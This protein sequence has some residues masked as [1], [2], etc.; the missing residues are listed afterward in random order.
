MISFL[1]KIWGLARPYRWRLWL[2]VL[3]GIIAGVIE[4]LLIFSV[5]FVY[6]V[7]FPSATE[8]LDSR[9]KHLPAFLHNWII[10]AH[11]SLTHGLQE[12]HAATLLLV[13]VIPG[14]VFLRG[15]FTYLNVYLLQW[16]AIRTVTDLRTK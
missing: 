13:A 2:G 14:V 16:V 8:A 5:A 7:I 10:T 6:V 4:P 1:F 12:H 15:L 11:D 3:T 9:L